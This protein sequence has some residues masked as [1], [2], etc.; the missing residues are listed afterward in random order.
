MLV[1]L[2]DSSRSLLLL[3]SAAFVVAVLSIADM[4]LPQPYDGVILDPDRR[5]EFLVLDVVPGSGAE[6]AGIEPGDR[7]EGINRSIVNSR[8]SAMSLLRELEVGDKVA[9]LVSKKDGGRSILDVELGQRRHGTP[10]YA[11]ACL[12]GF[13][14]FLVGLFVLLRQPR[15]A[16]SRVFFVLCNLFLLFLVCRLRPASYSQV[17][18]VVLATGTMALLLLPAAFLHFFLIF[19]R[20]LPALLPLL[21]GSL[22]RRRTILLSV[23]YL[24]PAAVLVAAHV[25][26]ELS[27]RRLALIS[28]A[29]IANW[30]MLAA[31]MLVGLA[32]L[33]T[34]A[35]RLPDQRERRGAA[36]V[37]GGAI[38]GLLPFLVLAVAFPSFLHTERFLP[39]GVLPLTLVPATFAYAI[40][41]FQILDVRVILRKGLFYTA[42]TAVITGIY[43]LGIAFFNRA[44]ASTSLAGHRFFPLGVALAIVLLFEPLRRRLQGPVDRFFF[45]EQARLQQALVDMGSALTEQRDLQVVVEDLVGQLPRLLDL[46]FAALYLAR[47]SRMA[48]V[49]GPAELP[50]ELP[51]DLL[52]FRPHGRPVRIAELTHLGV[53][54][55]LGID[56]ALALEAC[57]VE[58]LGE[59]ATSR[60]KVGLVLLSVKG[61]RMDF[62]P[63]ELELLAGLLAQA[64]VALENSLLLAER[65]QEAELKR[66]L[67][68]AS[69]IQS[70]LLPKAIGLG[71]GWQVAAV[72]R[73]ARDVGGDFFAQLPGPAPGASAIV[74]GDVSGKSVPGALMMMAAH[75]VLHAL[76]M[77]HRPPEE[78]FD[79]ANRR[80]YQ[81]ANRSFV[82][83]GYLA[84]D[85]PGGGLVY[86]VA[87]QPSPL[88]RRSG[89][90][91]RELPAP[92]HRLPLGAL[93][94]G[95]YQV[96][97]TTL[98][99]GELLLGYSDGVVETC[100][101]EGEF[102][103]E[104]RL[105]AAFATAPPEPADAIAHLLSNLDAFSRGHAP[106]DDLTLV[107]VARLPE[108]L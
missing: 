51:C 47:G 68:I 52:P 66:E 14:F 8:H 11:Y 23:L 69:E 28:G 83:L 75:E 7:I 42:T 61:T 58:V 93:A 56:P 34:N 55:A 97:T 3:G 59:L 41:R 86:S 84:S 102:F 44:F 73:P 100:S 50:P 74:Y 9:Y 63:D 103:G 27:G 54:P 91:V 1:R 16:A 77:T 18:T 94:T 37:F 85:G 62:E 101:P 98:A 33:A 71:P 95:G 21:D 32:M 81:L 30:W 64:A 72:C 65:T 60:R 43:A 80:L 76:A 2:P 5:N 105:F 67:E 25:T 107:A 17:D 22:R 92:A 20:P 82:A 53:D 15:Q 40:V 26:S 79:L 49:A 36:L 106:Y 13:A 24:L 31:Y 45:G 88:L 70:S 46:D 12:L 104:E 96:C 39:Y 4:F 99:P 38:F 108:A 90:E 6:R 48:R 78:L 87:G 89:G 10:S 19:P 35:R 29:P 57:G